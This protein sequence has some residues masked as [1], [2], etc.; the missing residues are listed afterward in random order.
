M[1]ICKSNCKCVSLLFKSPVLNE[2]FCFPCS[3]GIYQVKCQLW[4][5]NVPLKSC[6]SFL[7]KQVHEINQQAVK[8]E[9]TFV[10]P[11]SWH[12]VLKRKKKAQMSFHQR[13]YLCGKKGAGGDRKPQRHTTFLFVPT[14]HFHRL[15]L[16]QTEWR[17]D[18][19]VSRPRLV[20]HILS[21]FVFTLLSLND[22]NINMILYLIIRNLI[23]SVSKESFRILRERGEPAETC[24]W[25]PSGPSLGYNGQYCGP[26]IRIS[27]AISLEW[28]FE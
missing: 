1:L 2:C 27:S 19:Q 7:R 26:S 6:L 28:T 21:N 12:S 23:F 9:I 5:Q 17:P 24:M 8:V 25:A 10:C 13:T 16:Y 15:S 11:K 4:P 3:C 22:Q 18:P 20:L 14:E